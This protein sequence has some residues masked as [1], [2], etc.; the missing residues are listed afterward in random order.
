[1]G[2]IPSDVGIDLYPTFDG[3]MGKINVP[4]DICDKKSIDDDCETY[5]ILDRSGSMGQNVKRIFNGYLPEA[6]EQLGYK[7]QKIKVLFFDSSLHVYDDVLQKMTKYPIDSRGATYMTKAVKELESR[8]LN[9]KAQKIRIL[10][11]SDGDLHDQQQTLNMASEL[12]SMVKDKLIINAQA[13]RFFTSSDQPDTRGLASILQLN[14]VGKSSLVDIRYD[15]DRNLIIKQIVDLFKDDGLDRTIKLSSN[16]SCMMLTPWS[17]PTNSIILKP[18][19][20]TIWFSSLPEELFI[21]KIENIKIHINSHDGVSSDK[22]EQ[23]LEPTLDQFINKLKVLKVVNTAESKNEIQ[24][25]ME[26]FTQLQNWIEA[27]K[28]DSFELLENGL[29]GRVEYFKNI[30]KKRKKSFLQLMSQIANDDKIS[31]LNSAQQAEYLRKVESTKNAKGL[32]RRALDTSL[33]F[34]DVLQKEVRNMHANLKELDGVL[35]DNE[36]TSFYSQDTVLGGIK[37]VC[38]LV[39]E[40]MLDDMEANDILQMIN[41]VGMAVNAEIGDYPDPMS[42]RVKKIFPG[43]FISM[44]DIT[45]AHLHSGGRKLHPFGFPA[46][47]ENEITACIPIVNDVRIIKFLRKYAPSMLEY[48]ASIG[49]RRLIAGVNMTHGYTLAAGIIK[50]IEELDKEKSSL[51]IESFVRLVKNFDICVGGYFNHIM[52]Y[53]KDQNEEYTYYIGNNGYSNMISTLYRLIKK[54]NTKHISKILRSIYS[55]EAYQVMRRVTKKHGLDQRNDYIETLLYQLLGIDLTKYA[56]PLT[57]LFEPDDP[58]PKHYDKYHIDNQLLIELSRS[59]KDAEYIALLP[60]LLKAVDSDNPVAEIQK[61]PSLNDEMISEVLEI[62]YDYQK[63]KFY[64]IVQS[65]LYPEKHLRVSEDDSSMIIMDLANIDNAENMVK[66]YVIKKYTNDYNS[67]MSKQKKEEKNI[68]SK[69]LVDELLSCASIDDYI[70]FFKNGYSYKGANYVISSESNLG[71]IE[72]KNSLENLNIDVP[73]RAKKLFVLYSGK[74]ENENIIWNN[75]NVLRINISDKKDLFS[76]C[77]GI[78]QFEAL[79]EIFKNSFHIYRDLPNRHGH[80]NE[81]P[82][83]WAMG[84]QTLEDMIKVIS[85]EEWEEYKKI[86]HNCCG[87]NQLSFNIN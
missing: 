71:F 60:S 84:Y 67:R 51:N 87:V 38:S 20:N 50:L 11:F 86:H 18:G 34:T 41:I 17:T 31:Q 3:Y 61:I 4:S 56:T 35:D 74:D 5:I 83:Y 13:I 10:A 25:I 36:Y 23:L 14:N 76:Q 52:P 55:F 54:N 19:E 43:C 32:A 29:R 64:S 70:N 16:K 46:I 73:Q 68:L 28:D 79:V 69:K 72:L 7:D 80:S 40:N 77:D 63:F 57:D 26:F 81:K 1:M 75:G 58:H 59:L 42:W 37:A 30:L 62:P 6:L 48:S 21:E 2:N 8:L 82:S 15:V 27:R 65:L 44:S 33:D 22:Y 12:A 53:I 85:K 9:T 66:E 39:D 47:E 24:K 45:M 78:N 49:M